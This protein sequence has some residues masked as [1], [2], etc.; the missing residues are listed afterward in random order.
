MRIKEK[1]YTRFECK[2]TTFECTFPETDPKYE[3]NFQCPDIVSSISYSLNF[4]NNWIIE[5]T[6][7]DIL[8]STDLGKNNETPKHKNFENIYFS[9]GGNTEISK[10]LRKVNNNNNILLRNREE[11]NQEKNYR[12]FNAEPENLKKQQTTET[13]KKTVGTSTEI[14]KKS[15]E[16]ATENSNISEDQKSSEFSKNNKLQNINFIQKNNN[17]C[18]DSSKSCGHNSFEE[19]LSFNQKNQSSRKQVKQQK[20]AQQVT[21]LINNINN[22]GKKR[23]IW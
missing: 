19:N 3:R 8:T 18:S 20:P 2:I 13:H 17:F 23:F 14:F 5:T 6:S 9:G 7:V 11:T 4:L 15:V 1:N 22:N 10:N 12:K 21:P 16:I